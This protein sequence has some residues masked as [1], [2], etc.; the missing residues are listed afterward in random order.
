MPGSLKT[1]GRI[2]QKRI[3]LIND[4]WSLDAPTVSSDLILM[5]RDDLDPGPPGRP[6]EPLGFK[7]W[8]VPPGYPGGNS[9]PTD[10]E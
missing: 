10:T 1:N 6:L 3:E 9:R 5:L 2:A 8:R 7:F 4:H